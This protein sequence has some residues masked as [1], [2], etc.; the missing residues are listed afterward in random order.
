ME[1]TNTYE[2]LKEYGEELA[3]LYKDVF[4]LHDHIA[5]GTLLNSVRYVIDFN[6]REISVGL[7]LNEVWKW[8][9]NDTKPH[10]PPMDKLIEWIKAKPVIPYKTYDGKL[11]DTKQLAYLIGRKISKEGT[12]GTH[13]L[14]ETVQALNYQ[15][16][17]RIAEAIAKDVQIEADVIISEFFVK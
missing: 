1:W 9:E 13:D 14:K 7:N 17:T 11:P 4:I 10:F 2:V 16:E 8:I 6:G 15:Y 12:K 5:T 3:N